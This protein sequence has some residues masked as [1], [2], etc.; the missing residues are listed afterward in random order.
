[1]WHRSAS[2]TSVFFMDLIERKRQS[3]AKG[4]TIGQGL[5]PHKMLKLGHALTRLARG[6]ATASIA[7]RCCDAFGLRRGVRFGHGRIIG[8]YS[9]GCRYVTL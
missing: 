5:I 3:G 6:S 7:R 1:M 2:L 9:P 4:H 8:I